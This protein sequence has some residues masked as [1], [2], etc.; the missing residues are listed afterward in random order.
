VQVSSSEANTDRVNANIG[1]IAY[2][3]AQDNAK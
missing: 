3:P 1:V 2:T